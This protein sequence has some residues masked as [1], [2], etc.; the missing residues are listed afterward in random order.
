M[1]QNITLSNRLKEVCTEKGVDCKTLAEK[2]G[3]PVKRV[4]RLVNGLVSNPSV[5]V[6]LRICDT[7]EISMDEFFKT[8]EFD[9]FRK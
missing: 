2:S 5:F 4:Y 6:M 3:L 1:E 8:Q 9:A 7:L